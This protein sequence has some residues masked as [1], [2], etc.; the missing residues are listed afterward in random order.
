M[1]QIPDDLLLHLFNAATCGKVYCEDTNIPLFGECAIG[2]QE[3]RRMGKSGALPGARTQCPLKKPTTRCWS[4]ESLR[5]PTRFSPG[6]RA[7]KRRDPILAR[8]YAV[9]LRASPHVL[10]ERV[11]RSWGEQA[12]TLAALALAEIRTAW[13]PPHVALGAAFGSGCQTWPLICA[14]R[15]LRPTVSGHQNWRI[16]PPEK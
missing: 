13:A 2:L 16:P 8:C 14:V 12:R 3:Q 1:S 5:T 15:G 10:H 11:L 9:N 6:G 4:A 7:R